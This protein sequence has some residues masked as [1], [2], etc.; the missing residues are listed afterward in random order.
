MKITIRETGKKALVE[1]VALSG[2]SSVYTVIIKGEF[3]PDS[4]SIRLSATDL[5]HAIK[6]F[7]A[8]ESSV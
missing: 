5:A 7:D 2:N 6:I 4:Y 1:E 8:I 3:Y